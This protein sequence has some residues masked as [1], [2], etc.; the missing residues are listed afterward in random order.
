MLPVFELRLEQ[1][2]ALQSLPCLS[3][4]RGIVSRRESRER[5]DPEP[6]CLLAHLGFL[7]EERALH[8]RIRHLPSRRRGLCTT[9]PSTKHI[10]RDGGV[11]G[12]VHTAHPRD[13]IENRDHIIRVILL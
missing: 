2:L 5:R 12:V 8:L 6:G 3:R 9:P 10:S 11:E 1:R 13:P 4:D 7:L